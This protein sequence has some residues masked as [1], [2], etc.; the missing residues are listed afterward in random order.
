MIPSASESLDFVF[1]SVILERVF[2][3]NSV[4]IDYAVI[5]IS[6]PG[7]LESIPLPIR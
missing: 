2:L 6:I 3:W 5:V 7:A 1:D 4:S